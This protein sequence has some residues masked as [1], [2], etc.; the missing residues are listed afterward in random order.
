[1]YKPQC[2]LWQYMAYLNFVVLAGSIIQLLCWCVSMRY[3]LPLTL[4]PK[5]TQYY[6][7]HILK[8]EKKSWRYHITWSP[9]FTITLSTC[10]SVRCIG[11]HSSKRVISQKPQFKLW[12]PT[13]LQW[14][15]VTAVFS[16]F[17]VMIMLMVGRNQ[18]QTSSSFYVSRKSF[19]KSVPLPSA[20][21]FISRMT[22]IGLWVKAT[23]RGVFSIL[24]S[25]KPIMESVPL[26]VATCWW[27]HWM[28]PDQYQYDFTS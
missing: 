10:P 27:K 26:S 18:I 22:L 8:Q 17:Y 3:N 21:E 16:S 4:K 28:L 19:I 14:K 6:I 20:S 5:F 25:P 15:T 1:M 23:A 9:L 13:I 24:S 2:R 12:Y 7:F 11:W